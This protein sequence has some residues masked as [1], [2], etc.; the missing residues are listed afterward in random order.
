M[1]GF[2][3]LREFVISMTIQN[4]VIRAFAIIILATLSLFAADYVL[5]PGDVLEV[6]AVGKHDLT[7]KQPISPDGT[8][9]LPFVGRII[10]QG[11][12]LAEL[13]DMLKNRMVKACP[14]FGNYC[15]S[16]SSGQRKEG[17]PL[18]SDF[19]CVS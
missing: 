5:H 13:D 14:R 2:K 15:K 17:R 7:T 4:T 8:V 3:S 19:C 18:Q 10:V 11:K 6:Q 12:T 9:A 16:G 1:F